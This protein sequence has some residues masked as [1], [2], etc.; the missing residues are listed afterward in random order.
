MNTLQNYRAQSKQL[1]GNT[2][3]FNTNTNFVDSDV[4]T[5]IE[6]R[7]ANIAN[8]IV[9]TGGFFGFN[10]SVFAS[11]G[12]LGGVYANLALLYDDII[13]AYVEDVYTD[14]I[15]GYTIATIKVCL[16]ILTRS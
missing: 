9:P 4:C 13:E 10:T 15:E 12:L 8:V 7:Q 16:K 2:G 6:C 14:V 1:A 5:T 11:R 3:L